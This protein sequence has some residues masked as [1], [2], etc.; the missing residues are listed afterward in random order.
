MKKFTPDQLKTRRKNILIAAPFVIGVILLMI[1]APKDE[2]NNIELKEDITELKETSIEVRICIK[3]KI[4][5]RKEPGTEFKV[6][7]QLTQGGL[8]YSFEEKKG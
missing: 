8:I 1:F 7:G 3:E 5:F 6:I 2:E 4:N